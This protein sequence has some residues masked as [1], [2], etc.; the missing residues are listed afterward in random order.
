MLRLPVH[1][2]TQT[3]LRTNNLFQTG[4]D[5]PKTLVIV[6]PTRIGK[7]EWA[8]SLGKHYYWANSYNAAD[9]VKL[10]GQQYLVLDDVDFNFLP[11]WISKGLWGGQKSFIATDKYM[12]KITVDNWNLPLV[13]I[14]NPDQDPTKSS[15]WTEWHRNN[16]VIEELFD[17]LY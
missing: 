10:S 11:V 3:C 8:R 15:K 1:L 9:L 12:K 13:Y 2:N 7:T 4:I 16:C 17:K 6:G 5:R 14:C